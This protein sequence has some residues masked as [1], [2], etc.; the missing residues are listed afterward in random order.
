[1]NFQGILDSIKNTIGGFFQPKLISPLPDNYQFPQAQ[2]ATPTPRQGVL[3]ADTQQNPPLVTEQQIRKGWDNYGDGNAPAA[4]MSAVFAD[5]ANQYPVLRKH[6]GLLPAMA[7]KES[8]G[9]K[10]N[11]KNWFN[12][13]L[14]VP[15]Y[16]ETNPETVIRSVA[17]A[18]GSNDSPSSQYYQKFRETGNIEDMLARYAPPGENDTNLYHKQLLDWMKMFQ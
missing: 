11:T 1:M 6:P 17:R 4:T 8:S 16:N 9:G 10:A 2:A 13:G 14:K 18:I 12:W 5:V 3:G 15:G 7:M